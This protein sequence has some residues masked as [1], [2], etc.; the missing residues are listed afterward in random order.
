MSNTPIKNLEIIEKWLGEISKT[1]DSN[2]HDTGSLNIVLLNLRVIDA[3]IKA[4]IKR[5]TGIIPI[6]KQIEGV[7]DKVHNNT[8]ELRKVCRTELRQAFKEIKEY[9]MSI[10]EK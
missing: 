2:V 8:D 3:H 6:V 9:I 10:T 1:N 7:K 4:E 5:E